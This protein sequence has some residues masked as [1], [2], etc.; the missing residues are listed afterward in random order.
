MVVTTYRKYGYNRLT[1]LSNVSHYS[2][3]YWGKHEFLNT[4]YLLNVLSK[5]T[6]YIE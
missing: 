6:H 3:Q 5:L 4:F 2:F 1:R